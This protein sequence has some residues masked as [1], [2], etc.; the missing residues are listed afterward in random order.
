MDSTNPYCHQNSSIVD[1]LSSQ[2][3]NVLPE[4][5]LYESFSQLPNGFSTQCTATSSLG[6]DTTI[7]RKERKKWTPTEDKMLISSWLNTSKD[8]VVGNEQKAGA[9]WKRIAAYYAASP[10]VES[11]EKREAIQCKQRWQKINDLVSNFCRC[12]EAAT[13]QKNKWLE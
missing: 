3:E 13:R 7:E 10:S 2:Q 4:P 9:F 1:L 11:S 12:F 6:E 8:P 5:F